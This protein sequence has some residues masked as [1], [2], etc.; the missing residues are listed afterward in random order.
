L[1]LVLKVIDYYIIIVEKENTL[2]VSS[3]DPI[4]S[5]STPIICGLNISSSYVNLLSKKQR[6]VISNLDNKELDHEKMNL[7]YYYF[8]VSNFANL[9]FSWI[10]KN[11][12]SIAK[13][14]IIIYGNESCK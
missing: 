6:E 9:S 13:A 12:K 4:Q 8:H 1:Y 14:A 2:H 3:I 10:G 7:K 5:K 11:I